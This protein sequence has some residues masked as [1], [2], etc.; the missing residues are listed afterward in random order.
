MAGVGDKLIALAEPL[1]RLD[2]VLVNP[3]VHTPLDKTAR[4]FRSLGASPL[5]ADAGGIAALPAIPDRAELLALIR[6]IGNDLE[7]PATAVTPEVED[8][9]AVLESC[10]GAAVAHIS[11]AGPTCFAIFDDAASAT[12]AATTL[13][14]AHPGWWTVPVVIG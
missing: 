8:V 2:A 14:G 10:P 9:L 6:R 12:A 3:M 13:A 1:S 7:S 5:A 11:G 4:V